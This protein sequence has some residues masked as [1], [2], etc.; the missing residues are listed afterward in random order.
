MRILISTV[1]LDPMVG[2]IGV[3][4]GGLGGM[5]NRVE[6]HVHFLVEKKLIT[7]CFVRD[8]LLKE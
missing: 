3:V 2:A 1:T 5:C 4:E 6:M 8:K 7:S